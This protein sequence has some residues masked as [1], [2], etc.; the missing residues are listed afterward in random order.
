MKYSKLLFVLG[1]AIFV[2]TFS[3]DLA[4]AASIDKPEVTGG[5]SGDPFFDMCPIGYVI[6]SLSI[7]TG[8]R[9]DRVKFGCS[10][11]DEEGNVET[12]VLDLE[13]HGGSGGKD[14]NE[15]RCSLNDGA[16]VSIF[17]GSKKEI[18]RLGMICGQTSG[19]AIT[20][21][22]PWGGNGGNEFNIHCPNNSMAVGVTGRSYKRVDQLGLVCADF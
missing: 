10:K 22:G 11:I 1:V 14:L 20:V 19:E 15:V 7:S 2:C 5:N 12:A 9:V 13:D 21:H 8:S 17:G 3:V 4:K 18:D 16:V 6:T